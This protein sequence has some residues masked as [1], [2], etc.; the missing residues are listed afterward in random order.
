M[1]TKCNKCGAILRDPGEEFTCSK[2]GNRIQTRTGFLEKVEAGEDLPPIASY[3]KVTLNNVIKALVSGTCLIAL[4]G[5]CISLVMCIILFLYA[6]PEVGSHWT[7]L[8]AIPFIMAPEPLGIALLTGYAALG[9]WVFLVLMMLLTLAVTFYPERE[10]LK[11]TL[12]S[13]LKGLRAPSRGNDSTLFMVAQMFLAIFFFDIVYIILVY[14][15]GAD[16]AAPPFEEYEQWENL[17][18]F[19]NASVWEEIAGRVFLIG[20][21][22]IFIRFLVSIRDGTTD[23]YL[24]KKKKTSK[25]ILRYL[26]GGHGKFT[27]VVVGLITFSSL[28]FGFAHLSGWDMWK[29]L[30]TAV[31]GF[32]FGYLYVKKG[33]HAAILLHFMF[34]YLG[35]AQDYL[36]QTSGVET[37]LLLLAWLWVMVGAIYFIYYSGKVYKFFFEPDKGW[38][39]PRRGSTRAR[40]WYM[41]GWL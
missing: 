22:F 28:M 11:K 31:S 25:K 9:Y 20:I 3:G 15:G 8:T 26:W 35:M 36:P 38:K 2:C 27:P 13:S 40:L 7:E 18:G 32:G 12:F 16:P 24:A 34:D 17:Y 14:S 37:A 29:I 30:P 6:I 33:L 19:L 5:F 1:Y 39:R 23:R 21:P 10:P 41:L 4:L